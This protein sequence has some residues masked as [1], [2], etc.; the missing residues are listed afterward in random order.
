MSR[1]LRTAPMRPFWLSKC[2]ADGGGLGRNNIT[3]S[4]NLDLKLNGDSLEIDF[5]CWFQ[6]ERYGF[7][8]Q[9]E[10][11]FVVGEAKSFAKN[12]FSADDVARLKR[13]GEKM[14]GTFL[15]FA[16]LKSELSDAERVWIARLAKWGTFA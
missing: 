14:P 16:T 9:D 15:V 13:V 4:T 6:R 8:R 11:V 5:A 7:T 10:P 2:I 3:F 1:T 12:S